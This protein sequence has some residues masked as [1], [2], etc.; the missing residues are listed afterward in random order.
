[1]EEKVDKPQNN[2]EIVLHDE[3]GRFIK[4]HP[5]VGGKVIGSKHKP[6]FFDVITEIAKRDGKTYNDFVIEVVDMVIEQARK[7]NWQAL[8]EFMDRLMGPV[9]T[10]ATLN[11][12]N[13]EHLTIVLDKEEI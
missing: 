7:G 10:E 6:T 12:E 4:G 3:S 13:L 5:K 8:K 11:V 9:K 2:A 1:M